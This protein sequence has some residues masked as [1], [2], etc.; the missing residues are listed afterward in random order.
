MSSKNKKV[1]AKAVTKI[2]DLRPKKNPKGG[3]SSRPPKI[4]M[5]DVQ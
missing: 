2:K 1:A 3:G 4:D 5:M